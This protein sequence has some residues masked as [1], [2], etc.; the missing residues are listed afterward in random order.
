MLAARDAKR[1]NRSADEADD[2]A[3]TDR[4][5]GDRDVDAELR[6]SRQ[7]RRPQP[8][9]QLDRCEG[10]G[11]ADESAAGGEHRALNEHVRHDP[12]AAGADRRAHGDLAFARLRAREEQ[13]RDVHACDQQHKGDR[14]AERDEGRSDAG[15]QPVLHRLDIEARR[16]AVVLRKPLMVTSA[17]RRELGVGLRQRDARRQSRQRHAS[18]RNRSFSYPSLSAKLARSSQCRPQRSPKCGLASKTSTTRS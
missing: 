15:R 5:C 14:G 2:R 16:A 12:R 6:L 9:E 7:V 17:H 18:G 1:R 11:E 3:K 10:D 4:K 13:I 8:I